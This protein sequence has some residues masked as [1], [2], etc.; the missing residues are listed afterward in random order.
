MTAEF[1]D[2]T[3]WRLLVALQRD[4]RASYAEL[5]RQVSMSPSAVTERL[6][7][8]EDRGVIAGYSAIPIFAVDRAQFHRGHSAS[9]TRFAASCARST[10][11][12]WI[13]N[14]SA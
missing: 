1:L 4:A 6:R 12:G 9:V 2:D 11:L 8:L 10:D 7:R 13:P 3:D 14:A 5:A